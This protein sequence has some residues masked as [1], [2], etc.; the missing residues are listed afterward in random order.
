MTVF[1]GLCVALLAYYFVQSALFCVGIF[2]LPK[3]R[4]LPSELPFASVVVAARNEEENVARVLDSLLRVDYPR[5]RLE[6]IVSDGASTDRTTEIVEDYAKRHAFI[7]LHRVDQNRKIRGKANAIHQAVE[8]AKG[9]FIFLTDADCQVQPTWIKETLRFFRDDVG[10][11]CGVT[12]PKELDKTR[13][14]DW[15]SATQALDWCYILGVSSGRASMGFPIGGIGN[16]FCFRKKTYEEIGGYENLR[17][18]VT[19][20]FSLFQAILKS[21]WKIVFPTLYE[22]RNFTE[23]LH[24]I[25]D[26]CAQKKRWTLGGL[27]ASAVHAFL[28]AL[29]F[30]VHL[31]TILAF[32][33]LPLPL[34]LGLMGTKFLSDLLILVPV[35]LK[36][37]ETRFLWHF[38]L[39]EAYYYA[40]VFSAPFVI[41]F[42]R[43][44]RWKGVAYDLIKERSA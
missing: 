41:L 16:N 18:S 33:F 26:L 22:T 17:F 13:R 24:S 19:E 38:L 43:E 10:L 37:R 31:F 40:F 30:L 4:E 25:A 42:S 12:I 14:D 32:F 23:P 11:V 34:A 36:L 44:V 6:I 21:R 27:D 3:R 39:F 1:W 5:E 2:R 9:E 20:D 7:K 35:L 8:R 28:A 15:F 29:M